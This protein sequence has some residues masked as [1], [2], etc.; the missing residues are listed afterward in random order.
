M[1]FKSSRNA[2]VPRNQPKKTLEINQK[3]PQKK[4]LLKLI[5]QKQK[6]PYKQIKKT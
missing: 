1:T 3:S 4:T 2:V 6:N 5:N